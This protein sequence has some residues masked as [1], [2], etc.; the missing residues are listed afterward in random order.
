MDAIDFAFEKAKALVGEVRDYGDSVFTE[1]D[2]RVKV[3][4]RM[5]VEVLNWPYADFQTEARAGRGYIDYVLQPSGYAR[6]VLEAKRDGRPFGIETRGGGFA[7]KL[8][9]PAFSSPE[10]KDGIEQAVQYCAHSNAE[11]ACVTNGREWIVFRGSRLGD[12]KPT[13]AGKAFLFNSLESVVENFKLFYELLEYSHILDFS[14]RPHFQEAEGS[15]IRPLVVAKSVRTPDSRTLLRSSALSADLDRVMT[16]FF[17]RLSGDD[18]PALIDDCF[19]VTRESAAADMSLVRISEDLLSRIRSLDTDSG[20]EL[21]ELIERVRQTKQNEFVIIVGTKGAGKS[22]FVDRFFRKVLPASVAENTVLSR[23]NLADFNGD[24][25]SVC[26]WM[27]DHLL[28]AMEKSVF[29]EESPSYEDLQ[30][31]YFDEYTRWLHGPHKYLYENNK[32]QFKIKFGDFLADK[33]EHDPNGY[34]KRMVQHVVNVRKKLP[35]VV[36]DNADH[37]THIFQDR[38]FQYARSLYEG[39]LCMIIMPITDRTSWQFS[40]HG[41]MRSFEIESLFLPTPQPRVVIARRIAHIEKKLV[42]ERERPSTSYFMG[43][44]IRLSLTDLS[45]FTATLQDV[46][47]TNGLPSY[48]IGLLANGD[49]RRCLDIARAIVTSPHMGI[50]DLFQAYV[51]G[52]LLRV[53]L[54]RV[55]NSM[56]RGRYDIYPGDENLYVQNMFALEG[57][58]AAFPSVGIRILRL[59]RDAMK[60][61]PKA[62]Y[63]SRDQLFEYFQAMRVEPQIVSVWVQHLLEHGL[64]QCYD[65]MTIN[66]READRIRIAPSGYLHMKWALEDWDYIRAMSEVSPIVD[67]EVVALLTT[68]QRVPRRARWASEIEAFVN[69]VISS[70]QKSVSV[71]RHDAYLSQERL[72]PH[73]RSTIEKALVQVGQEKN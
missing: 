67:D 62:P 18:D 5:L 71:P 60:L 29:G 3:I 55:K 27:D 39:R 44:G 48:W 23:I 24:E 9:G 21:T 63:V 42:I 38:V 57:D 14:F 70:D 36:F 68:L 19:V 49:T 31:M 43:R 6:C 50:D 58:L 1:Q 8:N 28:D 26:A 2:T 15:I 73:W 25:S 10:A 69:Y 33:R 30:G 46:F 66:F 59:L 13:L 56:F 41:P 20:T 51:D 61:S 17:R 64:C 45:K 54:W 40:Q 16:S 34:I 65:P 32:I 53:P 22:T 35:C 4:D 72:V 12:G 11:L 7:Y 37:F 47:V 52:S